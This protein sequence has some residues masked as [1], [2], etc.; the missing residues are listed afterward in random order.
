MGAAVGG[1]P[2]A[3]LLCGRPW[4]VRRGGELGRTRKRF[5]SCGWSQRIAIIATLRSS[6]RATRTLSAVGAY[7]SCQQVGPSSSP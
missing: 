6:R 3:I 4:L 2:V 5:G 1:V 7:L